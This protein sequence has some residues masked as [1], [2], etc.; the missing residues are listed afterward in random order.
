MANPCPICDHPQRAEIEAHQAAR[1]MSYRGMSATFGVPMNAIE[2]HKAHVAKKPAALPTV[3]PEVPLQ[4][5]EAFK[6]DATKAGRKS[7]VATHP[8]VA[9]ISRH[10]VLKTLPMTAISKKYDVSVDAI[11]RYR[12]NL[13]EEMVR[14]IMA[15]AQAAT[16]ARIARAEAVAET[17]SE[18]RLDTS[19]AYDSLARRVEK[20][21]SKAE[22]NDQD[23]LALAAMEGLRK[24]LRDVAT[25]Q[26]KLSQS[27]T[28]QVSLIE[29][30]EWI[31]LRDILEQVF[32][33]FPAAGALFLER[34]RERRLTI[35]HGT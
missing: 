28:V 8:M 19:A 1:T 9:D 14:E 24:V 26:G 12:D 29:S 32:A 35:A 34:V 2:R 4:L 3:R 23:S 13:P 11:I 17:L 30:K 20:L 22:E 6:R 5:D 10:I 18:D 15:A 21:I 16:A 33:E 27:L 7:T 25:M 31:E